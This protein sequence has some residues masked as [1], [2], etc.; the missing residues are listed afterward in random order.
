MPIRALNGIID[1]LRTTLVPEGA[2]PTDGELLE[3]FVSHREP[4][5][6]EA[7]VRRHGPMVW[8]VCRRIL[9]D[10]HDA[11]DAFQ[12]TFLVLVRKAAS[13]R[14]G[15]RVGNW[16]YGVAHQTSLKARA[17]RQNRESRQL[18]MTD[19]PEPAV[20][21][22]DAWRDLRAVLDQELSRLPE[23]YRTVI[24]LCDLEGKTLQ[25][26]AR[27]LSLPQGTVASRLARGREMLARRL[28]RH[29]LVVTGCT[30][31]AVLS[32]EAASVP[33]SVLYPTIKTVTLV[34][35][36]QAAATGLVSARA[37]ALAEGVLKTMSLSRLKA[38]ATLLL[39]VAILACGTAGFNLQVLSSQEPKSPAARAHAPAVPKPVDAPPQ[40][41]EG[42]DDVKR[43]QGEWQ[44]VDGE[45]GGK[46]LKEDPNEFRIGFK[47]DEFTGVGVGKT[48]YTLDTSKSPRELHIH[49]LDGKLKE[50]TLR[51]IY[52]F[53]KDELK[54]CMPL[55]PGSAAPTEFKTRPG[56][57]L[58]VLV[59][60]RPPK[61]AAV[62][63]KPD[64]RANVQREWLRADA[65]PDGNYQLSCVF[66]TSEETWCLIK[67][68]TRDGK[69]SVSL[70]NAAEDDITAVRIVAPSIPPPSGPA[71]QVPAKGV[72]IRLVLT[73]PRGDWVFDGTFSPPSLEAR[74]H[75]DG[76]F[77][78]PATLTATD[79][80]KLKF[81]TRELPATPLQKAL[82]LRR[83]IFALRQRAEFAKDAQEKADLVKQ[84]AAAEK[85]ALV[86]APKLLRQGFEKD[87]DDPLIFG[88]AA[89]A[90]QFATSYQIPADELRTMIARADQAAARYGRGW[91]REFNLQIAAALAPQKEFAALALEIATRLEKELVPADAAA[92][93]QRVLKALA[94]AQ[95]NAGSSPAVQERLARLLAQVEET[96][97]REYRAKV[98]PFKPGTF[99]RRKT[100]SDRA[101][102]L[103]LFTGTQCPPCVAA[104]VAFDALHQ[105]YQ[106][107]ELV[108][109]QYHLHIP[110]PDPLA[111]ADSEARFAY[112]A[113]KFP[114]EAVGVPTTFF[115][116]KP[117]TRGGGP[118]NQAQE[119]YNQFQKLIDPLLET[120]SAVKLSGGAVQQGNQVNI[121]VNVT[122][123]QKP[124]RDVRLRLLLVEENVRFVGGNQVRFHHHVVRSMVGGA[125]GFPL[126]EKDS[127]HTATVD[128]EVVRKSLNSYLEDYNRN[129]QPFP[130]NDRPLDLANLR[131]I[132][133]VQDEATREIVQ[134]AEFE[135][136]AAKG[137]HR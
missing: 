83:R 51:M 114:D 48:K 132:A 96:L 4:A 1:Y 80:T 28:A 32:Q 61:D 125:D 26:A 40:R 37:A 127:K 20:A 21:E 43:L 126:E 5:A 130:N 136:A 116:G 105:T 2:D 13:I 53:E 119:K 133:L 64:D 123:L 7:L 49:F 24:V 46:P 112:Y 113:K 66:Q 62:V 134:A 57:N 58:L 23:K 122:D 59:L 99:P 67:L 42:P 107:T 101:V 98:P 30:L 15:A 50:Q 10:H 100:A 109:L 103:E 12:V 93:R 87:A 39:A 81:T 75:L 27:Q 120:P 9:Q 86:E 31:A 88:A 72:P 97:D 89:E 110:G 82:R 68:E 55:G 108:L 79:L 104:T 34:A 74:G 73:T 70:L 94:A 54:L 45:K 90:A 69:Q 76:A 33:S 8:G 111:N 18:P 78:Y 17:T 25:E 52:A 135:I 35:P 11:E 95:A 16:L 36:G 128:L 22:R 41:N 60:R 71:R 63:K 85:E 124:G 137:N 19:L 129:R 121:Q 3:R 56:S 44:A 117:D 47:G 6:L 131:L 77:V 38:T 102:V 118:M 115:N 29:D 106:P 14:W 92:T 65:P 91:Q 84:V